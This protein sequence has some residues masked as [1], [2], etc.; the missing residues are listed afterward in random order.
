MIS[1]KWNNFSWEEKSL[2]KAYIVKWLFMSHFWPVLKQ[3]HS[4]Y[5]AAG[6]AVFIGSELSQVRFTKLS[7]SKTV[8]HTVVIGECCLY[9]TEVAKFGS[10]ENIY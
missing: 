10:R 8:K 2:N 4:F 7:L 1:I 3:E 9:V 5:E 6:L